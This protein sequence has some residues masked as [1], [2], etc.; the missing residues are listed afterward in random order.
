MK[1][2]G[3]VNIYNQ[4]SAPTW[5]TFFYLFEQEFVQHLH[6]KQDLFQSAAAA[7]AETANATVSS[8]CHMIT[9]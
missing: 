7:T 1:V 6:I 9:M 5:K 3:E 2:V 4:L 8:H